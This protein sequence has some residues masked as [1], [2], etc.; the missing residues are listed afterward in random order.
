MASE[1]I[2]LPPMLLQ[3]LQSVYEALYKGRF[4]F[5]IHIDL[6]KTFDTVDHDILIK[7]LDHYGIRGVALE[8]FR[9]YLKDRKQVT[10]INETHSEISKI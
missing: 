10:Y 7:K 4:V 2:I 9:S 3:I 5:G 1:L 8:W 6:K